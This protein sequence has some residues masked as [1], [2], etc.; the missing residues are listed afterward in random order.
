MFS[1]LVYVVISFCITIIVITLR[2]SK[3]RSHRIKTQTNRQNYSKE[4][5][6]NDAGGMP[7]GE[8]FCLLITI[9]SAIPMCYSRDS[10]DTV[11]CM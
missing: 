2:A 5:A 11:V 10:P 7:N 9:V 6:S 3:F 4:V 1:S 8:V